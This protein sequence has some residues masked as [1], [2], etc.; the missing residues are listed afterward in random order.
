MKSPA[1]FLPLYSS[2]SWSTI[3]WK[4]ITFFSWALAKTSLVL[5]RFQKPE[6]STCD[7]KNGWFYPGLDAQLREVMTQ[8]IKK[9]IFEEAELED[10]DAEK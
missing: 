8:E 9:V 1:K 6:G 3:G 4:E 10:D 5:F 2:C 7:E